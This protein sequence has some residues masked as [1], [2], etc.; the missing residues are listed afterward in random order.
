MRTILLAL[1]MT[2]ARQAGAD[3]KKYR[4]KECNDI[5]EVIDFVRSKSFTHAI[6]LR[7][8]LF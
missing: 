2:L 6:Y 4:K 7:L 5:C 1:L 8:Q 3:I